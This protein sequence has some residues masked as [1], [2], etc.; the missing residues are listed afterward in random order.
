MVIIIN[1]IFTRRA[2]ASF[3]FR[4]DRCGIRINEL[5]FAKQQE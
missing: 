3:I 2:Q 5:P 1:M 4:R